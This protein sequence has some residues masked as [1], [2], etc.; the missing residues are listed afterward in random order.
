MQNFPVQPG[1]QLT[2]RAS[3]VSSF[4]PPPNGTLGGVNITDHPATWVAQDTLVTINSVTADG[5]TASATVGQQ[6][7]VSTVRWNAIQRANGQDSQPIFTDFTLTIAELAAIGA[8]FSI[9]I[10]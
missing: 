10:R 4:D 9:V 3:P 2:L 8:I 5:L 7:G 1:Q 6:P